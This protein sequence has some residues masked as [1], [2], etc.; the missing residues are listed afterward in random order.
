[1]PLP[2]RHCRF[3]KSYVFLPRL[4]PK[5][6]SATVFPVFNQDLCHFTPAFTLPSQKVCSCPFRLPPRLLSPL[7]RK[8]SLTRCE[9]KKSNSRVHASSIKIYGLELRRLTTA[10][11]ARKSTKITGNTW[12][13][14]S[15]S[16]KLPKVNLTRTLLNSAV[17]SQVAPC[18]TQEV[19]KL[20][21]PQAEKKR[22]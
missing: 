2:S 5:S 18:R 3:L 16:V 19:S 17:P 21:S 10:K 1:M 12:K 20:L 22:N 13:A 4:S 15:I 9:R 14:T 6:C 8:N 11:F 7:R